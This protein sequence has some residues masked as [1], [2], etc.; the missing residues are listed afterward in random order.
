MT[1]GDT[2]IRSCGLNL[3]IFQS[4]I[5][6]T[7][8]FKSGLKKTTAAAT[9]VIVGPVGLHIDKIFF[10]YDRFDDIAKVFGDG[11]TKTFTNDLAGVLNCKLDFT[12]FVPVGVDF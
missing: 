8:L 10:T 5:F 11:V 1:A 4:S 3:L 2:V 6:E 12:F 9:A 7:L